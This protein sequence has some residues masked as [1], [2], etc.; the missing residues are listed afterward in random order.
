MK[1]FFRNHV[2]S[3]LSLFDGSFVRLHAC[4]CVCLPSDVCLL[5]R[6]EYGWRH[7]KNGLFEY[8]L[9]LLWWEWSESVRIIYYIRHAR[10]MLQL[11]N[12]LMCCFPSC[13]YASW[14]CWHFDVHSIW[15]KHTL[16]MKNACLHT[17]IVRTWND[18][19]VNLLE[20]WWNACYCQQ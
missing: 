15:G 20:S 4:V 14:Y 12:K 18:A 3:I 1:A 11:C 2:E 10:S 16:N 19:I 9:R 5:V 8:L 17:Y 7:M 13:L 6:G